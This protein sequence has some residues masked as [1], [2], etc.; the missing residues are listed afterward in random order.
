MNESLESHDHE[1]EHIEGE[2]PTATVSLLAG[3]C[4]SL[5]GLAAFLTN[6]VLLFTLYKDPYKY[7]Q[8]R[9]TTFFVV[10]LSLSDF[11]GGSFVQP[12]YSVYMFCL[13]AGVDMQKLYNISL[14]SSHVS[15]KIS[16][17]TVVAL[18]VDRYLAIK[19]SWKYKALITVRKVIACNILIWLFCGIFEASHSIITGTEEIFHSVDLHLQTT[20]PLATLCAVYAAT[21]IEFRRYSRNVVFVHANTGGRSRVFVRNMALEKKIV[22]T[23]VLIIIVLFIAL[24]PY[25]IVTNLEEQCHGVENSGIC[26]ELG[27]I[28]TR[29][30][31]VPMLC[32]SCALNPFL[33]AWRIPQYRQ[34]L[35]SVGRTICVRFR[36][37]SR[38]VSTLSNGIPTALASA[39]LIEQNTPVGNH[40][41]KKQVELQNM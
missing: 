10:S 18:S 39:S 41:P 22:L 32:I 11:I 34:A 12:L 27:F 7:F 21:Y 33:Y 38:T 29:A 24:S 16:I 20:V 17:L 3:I 19:L 26:S 31:S 23:V 13:T 6:S 36:R 37:R 2:I 5:F 4:S 8:A 28:V 25:L 40:I 14:I 1:H 30:L 15:T 9:A 35:R